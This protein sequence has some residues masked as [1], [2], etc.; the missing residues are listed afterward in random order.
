MSSKGVSTFEVDGD[1]NSP[2]HLLLQK[3]NRDIQL[4]LLSSLLLISN[5]SL[6]ITNKRGDTPLS[7]CVKL[8]LRDTIKVILSYQPPVELCRSILETVK[9]ENLKAP[10]QSYIYV[11]FCFYYFYFVQKLIYLIR[12]I[13]TKFFNLIFKG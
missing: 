11:L 10:L 12:K 5:E 9:D 2:V 6:S 7:L 4:S 8:N 13:Q 3:S 1:G